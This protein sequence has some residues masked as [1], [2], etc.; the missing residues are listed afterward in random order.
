MAAQAQQAR[1]GRLRPSDFEYE[2]NVM[3]LSSYTQTPSAMASSACAEDPAIRE[4]RSLL[5]QPL[6]VELTDGRVI[7]GH[8]SC[9]DKQGNVL[10]NNAS[11]LRWTQPRAEGDAAERTERHLG[12]VLVPRK[13]AV[14]FHTGSV[15]TDPASNDPA[16]NDPA[17]KALET[18]QPRDP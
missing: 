5:D 8:F 3:S 4:C 11:E 10:L 12:T 6:R 14:A 9:L 7:V 17:S 13:W 18:I 1:H 2:F 15:P 16:S